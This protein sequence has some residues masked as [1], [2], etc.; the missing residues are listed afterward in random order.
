MPTNKNAADFTTR[1]LRVLD[2]A[3]EKKWWS[4]PDILQKEE[5]GWPVDQIDTKKVSD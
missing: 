3:K 2:M 1:S 5:S 4:G